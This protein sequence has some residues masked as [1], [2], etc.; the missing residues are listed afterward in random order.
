[1][2]NQVHRVK[3]MLKVI[4]ICTVFIAAFLCSAVDSQLTAAG[5]VFNFRTSAIISLGFGASFSLFI[6]NLKKV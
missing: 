6:N 4:F 3:I 1:M 2:Q 5:Q